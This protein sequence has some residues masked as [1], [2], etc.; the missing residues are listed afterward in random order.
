[1]ILEDFVRNYFY[2]RNLGEIAEKNGRISG[3]I[4]IFGGI[5]RENSEFFVRKMEENIGISPENTGKCGKVRK[6]RILRRFWEELWIYTENFGIT[7]NF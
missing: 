5:W 6:I 1:M 4:R 7:G 2:R 3:K